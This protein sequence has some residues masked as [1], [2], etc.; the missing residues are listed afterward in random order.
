MVNQ[1]LE[2]DT[3]QILQRMEKWSFIQCDYDGYQGWVDNKQWHPVPE[4]VT[5]SVSVKQTGATSPSEVAENQYL[6][7]PY[8]WGGRSRGGIDCSGLTQVCF[9]A[10]GI[11]L[12]R[13]ASQQATQ[14]QSV[15][16]NEARKDD[17]AFFCNNEGKIVHVGIILDKMESSTS[18][19][20][21]STLNS[22]FLIIH[23]SG[24]VRI[25]CLD[26]NGILNSDTRQYTHRLHSIRRITG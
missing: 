20:Q 25:D 4:G 5:L 11:R 7:V 6:G 9:K 8:L 14:G 10:C 24:E 3:F 17:L 2:G 22:Q 16:L 19:S 15:N 13:D 18:D 23:A 21:L 12:L 1:L 26:E